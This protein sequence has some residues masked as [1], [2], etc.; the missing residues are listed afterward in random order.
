MYGDPPIL[1]GVRGVLESLILVIF[2]LAVVFFFW[3]LAKFI[4][5]S[6]EEEA[7]EEGRRMMLWGIIGFVVMFGLWGIVNFLLDIFFVYGPQQSIQIPTF[8]TQVR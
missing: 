7:K 8:P 6:A 4:L 1:V 3:G 5:H 2:A